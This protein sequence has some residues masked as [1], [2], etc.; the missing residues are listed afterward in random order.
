GQSAGTLPGGPAG[1]FSMVLR[2]TTPGET[3]ESAG[4]AQVEPGQS[5]FVLQRCWTLVPPAQTE[6]LPHPPCP[7][8]PAL[9]WQMA[10][11]SGQTPAQS[12]ATVHGAPAL[13]PSSHQPGEEQ[14]AGLA[15]PAAFV[16]P[17]PAASAATT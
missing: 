7:A 6:Y 5:L 4:M 1:A 11:R 9:E 15:Q 14:T 13:V 10:D 3:V 8:A 2:Q 16:L 17:V 12:A